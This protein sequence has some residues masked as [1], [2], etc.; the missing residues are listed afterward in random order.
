[1]LFSSIFT[2][3]LLSATTLAVNDK[4]QPTDAA[5]FTSAADQLIS[6]YI[7]STALPVFESAVSSAASAATVT[8]DAKSLIYSALVATS[9]P[10]WF[11]SAVPSAWSSQIA[12][13]ESG[14]DALRGTTTAETSVVPVIIV[15][16]TTD[17]AGSTITSSETT[18]AV[19]ATGTT[20]GVNSGSTGTATTTA[21][22]SPPQPLLERCR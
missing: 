2:V 12:A 3:A 5:Q 15:I 8:G 22:V 19:L 1:M 21:Y 6:K 7:P 10:G 4:R 9:I 17:S 11:A 20:I 13:L 18:T 16:T 14:I